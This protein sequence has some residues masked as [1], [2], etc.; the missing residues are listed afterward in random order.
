MKAPTGHLPRISPIWLQ[1]GSSSRTS[2]WKSETSGE[3]KEFLTKQIEEQKKT[4]EESEQ[5][6]QKYKEQ[7][8]IVQLTPFGGDKEKENIAMQKLGG[9]T[10]RL[11]DEQA[12]RVE[13]EARYKEV[14]DL[15]SKGVESRFNP[16]DHGQLS[17]PET[18]GE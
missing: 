14:Q 13:V 11:V 3:A 7:Y 15:L 16:P 4:L 1:R 17:H 8:G 12:R 18:Q 6:L 5:A 10:A 9:L 2:A